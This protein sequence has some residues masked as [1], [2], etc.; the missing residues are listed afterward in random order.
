LFDAVCNNGFACGIDAAQG[1]VKSD[2]DR[3]DYG[4]I[5]RKDGN[6]IFVQKDALNNL[7]C[8]T[9]KANQNVEFTVK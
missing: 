7:N 3:K 6:D 1:M 8:V 5:E 2:S 4:F 9:L